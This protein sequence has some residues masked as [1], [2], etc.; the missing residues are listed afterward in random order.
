MKICQK[1]HRKLDELF[2]LFLVLQKDVEGECKRENEEDE[3]S[4]EFEEGNAHIQK[5]DNVDSKNRDFSYKQNKVDPTEEYC[6]SA[7]P[8]LVFIAAK[9]K[10]HITC[11]PL[12][13]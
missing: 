13:S 6:H 4:Q 5:H 11:I 3:N 1:F 12:L 2:Y 9:K 8:F 10:V 7:N